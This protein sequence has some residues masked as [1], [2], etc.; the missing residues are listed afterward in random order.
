MD[1]KSIS[2]RIQ[3]CANIKN[4]LKKMG[5]YE[6]KLVTKH[7]NNYIHNSTSCNVKIPLGDKT[8]IEM[9]LRDKHQSGIQMIKL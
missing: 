6:N 1:H 2:T 5:I 9:C 7:M 4:Q 3:E 8:F